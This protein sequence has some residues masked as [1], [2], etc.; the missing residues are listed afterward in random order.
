MG[1]GGVREHF[2]GHFSACEVPLSPAGWPLGPRR[3]LHLADFSVISSQFPRALSRGY[4]SPSLPG[5]PSHQP[6]QWPCP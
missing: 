1:A 5:L 3:S 4:F 2:L 6:Q